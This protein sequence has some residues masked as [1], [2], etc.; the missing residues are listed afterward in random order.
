MARR[1]QTTPPPP[2]ADLESILA[3][4]VLA[5][6]AADR[7]DAATLA[8][9]RSPRAAILARNDPALPRRRRGNRPWTDFENDYLREHLGKISEE[10]I[11]RHLGRTVTGIHIRRK[12]LQLVAPSK[13]EDE[14]PAQRVAHLFGVD[15][16]A[17]AHWIKDGLLPA[18]IMPGG[19]RIKLVSYR[20]VRRFALTPENWVRFKPERV[21]DGRLRRLIDMRRQWWGDEW[22]P[23][24]RVAAHHG[25]DSGVVAQRIYRGQLRSLKWGN[26]F[27]RKSEALALT[28]HLGKGMP[29]VSRRRWSDKADAFLMLALAIGLSDAVIARLTGGQRANITYRRTCLW[30]SPV[31]IQALARQHHLAV[32]ANRRTRQLYADWDR[33]AGRFPGLAR[34]VARLETGRPLTRLDHACLAG[35]LENWG[36]WHARTAEQK[37]LAAR[38]GHVGRRTDEALRATVRAMQAAFG[39]PPAGIERLPAP[40]ACPPRVRSS[41]WTWTPREDQQLRDGFQT[42]SVDELSRRLGRTTAAVQRRAKALGLSAP[43]ALL[44]VPEVA[45]LLG[46]TAWLARHW[47]AQGLL[48]VTSSGRR[49]L[50]P[51]VAVRRFAA[52]P[53]NW[54]RFD[55]ARVTDPG[56]A[57][58]IALRRARGG[59]EYWSVAQV[60]RQHRVSPARVSYH[61][62]RGRL[63]AVRT[64]N[65]YAVRKSDAIGYHFRAGRGRGPDIR[66]GRWGEAADAFLLAALAIGLPMPVIGRLAQMDRNHLVGRARR[67]LCDPQRVRALSAQYRL[68][69]EVDARRKLVFADWHTHRRR[70]AVVDRAVGRWQ[71]GEALSESEAGLIG[72]ITAHWLLWHGRR[73]ARLRSLRTG[74]RTRRPDALARR[75]AALA[76]RGHYPFGRRAAATARRLLDERAG[77]KRPARQTRRKSHGSLSGRYR[78]RRRGSGRAGRRPVP[79]RQR[80]RGRAGV[81]RRGAD[82]GGR[83]GAAGRGGLA[84]PPV[85]VRLQRHGRHVRGTGRVSAGA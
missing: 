50:V 84:R 22:W 7:Q 66:H 78:N 42:L 80:A 26:H 61:I 75:I 45:R 18:R 64:G 8:A 83:R 27:I 3:A 15:C 63:P 37:R 52:N 70:F 31:R 12:R 25:V 28:F 43:S 23:I 55:P 24:G 16:H 14:W 68:K 33:Y 30:R 2:E 34:A 73:D 72:S 47:V 11:A 51:R 65:K 74:R 54:M 71:A 10:A 38:A 57:R 35:L 58:L 5:G 67:L 53:V 79:G 6:Q 13:R 81:G 77:H 82:R 59:E 4:A 48:P 76:E 21:T 49:R 17:V 39:K 1:A 85:A 62:A 56:L 32:R 19:R 20:A 40:V 44:T 46:V 9:G 60:A 41:R 69:V 29:G 36:R